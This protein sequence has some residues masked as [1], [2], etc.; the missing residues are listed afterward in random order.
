[1]LLITGY[2]GAALGEWQ[3]APGMEVVRKPFRLESL[4]AQ[5]GDLLKQDVRHVQAAAS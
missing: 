5:V 2:A 4:A 3:L 1:M